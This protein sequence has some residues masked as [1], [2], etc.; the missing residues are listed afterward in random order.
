[1]ITPS[2]LCRKA[3]IS[4]QPT[5]HHRLEGGLA[6]GKHEDRLPVTRPGRLSPETLLVAAPDARFDPG[7][8]FHRRHR[9]KNCEGRRRRHRQYEEIAM[10]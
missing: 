1:M 3:D 7:P 8:V 5:E 10:R 2:K 9:R 4:G 6:R